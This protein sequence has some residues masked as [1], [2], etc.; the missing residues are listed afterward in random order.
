ML[1]F[2]IIYMHKIP[3]NE[4]EKFLGRKLIN[5]T[6][7]TNINLFGAHLHFKKGMTDSLNQHSIVHTFAAVQN[8]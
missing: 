4:N 8:M 1:W 7:Y 5:K 2:V 6:F 3:M